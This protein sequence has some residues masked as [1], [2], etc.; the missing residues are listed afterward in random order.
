[1]WMAPLAAWALTGCAGPGAATGPGTPARP[2]AT[3]ALIVVPSSVVR[4]KVAAVNPTARYVILSYPIGHL[5]A[6]DRRLA[7]Y[8]RGLKVA[9]IRVGSQR[10]DTN[11][12]AD[13]LTGDCEAGD[14]VRD[15]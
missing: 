7:V 12:V 3:N 15:E 8:R 4:G 5:P 9:E 11:A 14:E 10:L 6:P 13:I 1:M 2:G